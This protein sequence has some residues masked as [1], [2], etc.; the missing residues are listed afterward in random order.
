[1]VLRMKKPR[2]LLFVSLCVL[3]L[4]GLVTGCGDGRPKRAAVSGHVT[5]D[6]RP[7]T[8]GVV[9]LI[10]ENARPATGEL[11][12]DG[13]YALSC[14]EKGDGAVLGPCKVSISG[15]ESVSDNVRKWHAPKSYADA[16]RSGLTADITEATD[17]LDFQLTW[18]GGRPFLEQVSAS[19]GE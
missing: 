16:E 19:G 17:S 12:S 10:P 14:F 3:F 13:R 4:A 7:L 5:I 2:R 15:M 8:H 11:D 1:M 9:R 18:G 6:G